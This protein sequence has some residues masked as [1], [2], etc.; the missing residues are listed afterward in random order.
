MVF[1]EKAYVVVDCPRDAVG[2]DPTERKQGGR[3]G[4]NAHPPSKGAVGGGD[5][6][7]QAE[8]EEQEVPRGLPKGTGGHDS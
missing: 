7:N 4:R 3:Q 8:Y 1:A 6:S 5:R 2:H